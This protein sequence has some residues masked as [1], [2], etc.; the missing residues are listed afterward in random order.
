MPAGDVEADQLDTQYVDDRGHQDR[1]HIAQLAPLDEGL[2]R[3]ERAAQRLDEHDQRR[4]A[5]DQPDPQ[6][7]IAG[8]GTI[9]SPCGA[10]APAVP[11]HDRPDRQKQQRDDDLHGAR[12]H[13]RCRAAPSLA[14]H[15][16]ALACARRCAGRIARPRRQDP[17]AVRAEDP[18]T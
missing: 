7:E 6:R 9:H 16:S 4:P 5:D 3:R 13:G 17:A 8:L 15:A 12:G 2:A 11:G 1:K 10:Q 18:A 14:H